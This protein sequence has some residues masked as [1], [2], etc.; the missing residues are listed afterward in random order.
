MKRLAIV[1]ILRKG[2]LFTMPTNFRF[3]SLRNFFF[4]SDCDA[5]NS[6]SFTSISLQGGWEGCLGF[7]LVGSNVRRESA[8]KRVP[9]HAC[10]ESSRHSIPES[11]ELSLLS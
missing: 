4:L 11:A 10:R 1:S 6:V 9:P 7:L 8:Y 2:N 5:K 3:C